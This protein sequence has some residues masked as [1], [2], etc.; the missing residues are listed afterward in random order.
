MVG[1]LC[2]MGEPNHS[3]E[4][5]IGYGTYPVFRSKGYMADAVGGMVGWAAEQPEVRAVVASTD[6][7]N[8]ASMAVLVKNG[9]VRTGVTDL[10]IHWKKEVAR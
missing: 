6:K 2:F 10:L 3:G 9:F 5:E 7:D 8:P 4:V 1:D